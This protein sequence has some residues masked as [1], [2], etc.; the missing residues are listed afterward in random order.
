MA[1]IPEIIRRNPVSRVAPR[2]V[3]PGQGWAALAKL[4][5]IGADFVKPAALDQARV[6]GE[7]SVYRD[8]DGKL[9]VE[10]RSVLGGDMAAVH[11]SAAYAKYLGQKQIDVSETF[12]ELSV[13]HEFDPDGFKKASDA[14]LQLIKADANIPSVLKEDIIQSVQTEA[15][16]RFNGLYNNEVHRNYSEANINTRA[17]RD[18]LADDYIALVSGG[19]LEAAAQKMAEIEANSK[20]RAD[21]PYITETPAETE[22]YLKGVRASAKASRLIR[23]LT[24]TSGKS[25]V[26]EET[27]ARWLAMLDDPDMAA[28]TPE[29]MT[30][31]YAATHG[32]IKGVTAAAISQGLTDS[33]FFAKVSRAQSGFDLSSRAV[34]GA[35]RPDSF[36]GMTRDFEMALQTMFASAPDHIREGLQISSGF[37]TP[38]RQKELWAQALKKY[39]SA[40]EARK[41]VA[42]P[43]SSQ[44]NHGNAADFRFASDEVKS[45]VH[46]NAGEFGLAFP[47]ANEDWHVE[48]QG[49]RVGGQ[50]RLRE[51]NRSAL[52]DAGLPIDDGTEFMALSFGAETVVSMLS[53]DPNDLVDEFLADGVIEDNPMLAGMTVRQLRNW[54]NREMTMKASDI[55]ARQGQIDMI[56]DPEVRAMA[57]AQLTKAF[58]VRKG[59]ENETYASCQERLA[60][61]DDTLTQQEITEDHNLSSQNQLTLVNSLNVGRSKQTSI[62]QT[63]TDLNN[64]DFF[65]NSFEN[66]DR[67]RVNDAY[68]SLIGDEAPLSETG[69]LTAREVA[70]RAGFLPKTMTTAIRSAINSG[71]PQKLATAMEFLGAVQDQ[72]ENLTAPFAGSKQIQDT[73]SDYSLLAEYGDAEQ[74]AQQ[75]IDGRDN[76]P[77][78]LTD[79]A[80]NKI[81]NLSF[82]DIRTHFDDW[83]FSDPTFGVEGDHDVSA[84][85]PEAI[86]TEM[87]SDYQRL[88]RDAFIEMGSEELAKNRALD[89]MGRIFGPNM[90][91]GSKRIMK[92]PPNL[93]PAYPPVAGSYAY[94]TD[95][96]EMEI[97]AI[98]FG[99][100]AAEQN[101]MTDVDDLGK[102]IDAKSINLVSDGQTRVEFLS[103]RPP[104]Y[105]VYYMHDDLLQQVPTRY[106]FDPSVAQADLR[107]KQ[108]IKWEKFL[109]SETTQ[110][111]RYYDN[112][113]IYGKEATDQMLREKEG[114]D[115]GPR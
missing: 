100:E 30:S 32:A 107:A 26:T 53:A 54:A 52:S 78:N 82:S 67:T 64:D 96:I 7:K 76:V 2:P 59:V 46:E 114:R 51:E 19:D 80:K 62:A 22:A 34:G 50:D 73:L 75:I 86:E 87:M 111:G 8:S 106:I 43:G 92:F 6:E 31:L 97:S 95:Q 77:K 45:W 35:K 48:L 49:A 70:D 81:K 15:S 18:M 4:S 79:L 63:I 40:E 60:S 37:R 47:L 16:R 1:R 74:A 69:Q 10:E 56:E 14:Y 11:N 84:L 27:Q 83:W 101:V 5:S 68:D 23:E 9:K 88:F 115:G 109:K 85:I 108:A 41:W 3:S 103:G 33:G 42:P 29:K 39:G 90:A 65:W 93:S 71:D 24:D 21:A 89:Q 36:T 13:Q 102:W 94:L 28:L 12:T 91:T 20:F 99:D 72:G 110:R 25:D 44:H 112:V 57:S 105:I 58:N 38:A 98:V 61:D 17:A 104:S 55:A 66:S 113:A